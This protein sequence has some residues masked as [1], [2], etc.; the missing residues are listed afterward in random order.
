MFLGFVLS[1]QGPESGNDP[2]AE[3]RFLLEVA[4]MVLV[5]WDFK[6]A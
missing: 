6:Q 2:C 3:V 1:V 5:A 4:L